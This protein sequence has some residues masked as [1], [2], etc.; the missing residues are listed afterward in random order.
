MLYFTY[1]KPTHK[2][3]TINIVV[4]TDRLEIA[5][6]AKPVPSAKR[7]TFRLPHVSAINPQNCDVSTKPRNAI[8]LIMPCSP[9]VRSRSHLAAGSTTAIFKPSKTAPSKA[10]PLLSNSTM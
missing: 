4:F 7:K 9:V 2:R 6:N 3:V 10:N 1:V 5:E 8:A